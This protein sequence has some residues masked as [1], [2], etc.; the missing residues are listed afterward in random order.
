MEYR[1]YPPKSILI[2]SALAGTAP[3]PST[4]SSS[5]ST[6]A[7]TSTTTSQTPIS[8]NPT[9]TPPAATS[10]NS[11]GSSRSNAGAI[12]GGVVGGVVALVAIALFVLW[13]ILRRRRKQVPKDFVVD[14]MKT[15]YGGSS[16]QRSGSQGMGLNSTS[17][18]P[19]SST[20][21]SLY[22]V[23]P[24]NPHNGPPSYYTSGPM[25]RVFPSTFAAAF[26]G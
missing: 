20:L 22:G 16:H 23:Q 1:N 15:D 24:M 3:L 26:D 2:I 13:L 21:P 14:E 10:A 19:G 17:P 5:S 7:P 4:S 9:E 25:V 11:T 6:S 8:N 18:P 12:A